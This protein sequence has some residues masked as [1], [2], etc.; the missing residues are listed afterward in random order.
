MIRQSHKKLLDVVLEPF[1]R[2]RFIDGINLIG[3][4][5]ADTGLGQSC[6]LVAAELEYSRMPYSVYQYDQLGIMSST[7][8][9]F[10]GKIS[11]DLPFNINLIHI[12]PHELGLAFQQ[13]G[14]K[15]GTGIIILGSGYW[16]LEEFPRNGSHVFTVWM[17]YGLHLNLSA[18]QSAKRQSFR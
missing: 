6:R 12:N 17:K 3:N 8:M 18:E 1:D 4:I 5:K 15:V 9:Q 11:S 10:A 7:D 16:E 2:T 14:Q 13:L